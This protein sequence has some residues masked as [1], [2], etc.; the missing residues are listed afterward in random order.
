[1][2]ITS[3]YTVKSIEN[4][5][6]MVDLVG[7]VTGIATGDVTGKLTIDLTT[8]I[9]SESIMKL[10]ALIHGSKMTSEVIVTME[11]I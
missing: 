6:V 7:E 10:N 4:N 5:N 3:N 11:K 9:S 2:I 1:M 8:G